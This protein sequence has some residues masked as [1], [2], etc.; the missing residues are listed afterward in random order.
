MLSLQVGSTTWRERWWHWVRTYESE[1]RTPLPPPPQGAAAGERGARR[2]TATRRR[3]LG[4]GGARPTRTHAGA[5]D[6]PE[7]A[8]GEEEQMRETDKDEQM[9]RTGSDMKKDGG[10]TARDMRRRNRAEATEETARKAPRKG[11]GGDK[12]HAEQTEKGVNSRT[13]PG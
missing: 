8:G 12:G 13:D 7:R 4:G 9:T 3:K 6:Q 11:A 1:W 10:T 5:G 2:K